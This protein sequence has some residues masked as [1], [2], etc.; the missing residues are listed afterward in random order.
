MSNLGET[1]E[2]YAIKKRILIE[3]LCKSI[4]EQIESEQSEMN[5]DVEKPLEDVK[6]PEM[7]KPS[8]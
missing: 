4:I 5:A 8:E 3:K 6:D 2:S 7:L 1:R